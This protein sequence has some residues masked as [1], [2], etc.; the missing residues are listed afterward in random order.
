[1]TTQ[2]FAPVEALFVPLQTVSSLA[3]EKAKKLATL[4]LSSLETYVTIGINQA[5]AVVAASTPEDF[6]A[7]ANKQTELFKLLSEKAIVDAQQIVLLGTEFGNEVQQLFE[8]KPAAAE[9]PAVN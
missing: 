4:Q 8:A 2:T 5:K 1:M 7:L 3:A 9:A 6:Q